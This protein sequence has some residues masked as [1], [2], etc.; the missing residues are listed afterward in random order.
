MRIA[1]Q[2]QASHDMQEELH[3]TRVT[4]VQRSFTGKTALVLMKVWMCSVALHLRLS[5]S[6][7]A[8]HCVYDEMSDM[9]LLFRVTLRTT[10]A[11]VLVHS[12]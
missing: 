12:G 9:L 1:R 8:T 10:S 4:E 7:N 5:V 6:V 3:Q 11:D 2:H